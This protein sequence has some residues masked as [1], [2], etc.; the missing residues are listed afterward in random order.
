MTYIV[1]NKDTSIRHFDQRF[2]NVL[3]QRKKKQTNKFTSTLLHPFSRLIILYKYKY[4]SIMQGKR[5]T[6]TYFHGTS[7][8]VKTISEAFLRK[9]VEPSTYLV[10]ETCTTCLIP[11]NRSCLL[12]LGWNEFRIR[13]KWFMTYLNYLCH[14]LRYIIQTVLYWTAEISSLCELLL[15]QTI[16]QF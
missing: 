11:V 7:T 10:I 8:Y 3:W 13:C 16:S 12:Y 5:E 6:H 15:L 14:G 4:T 1:F 2:Y 9:G